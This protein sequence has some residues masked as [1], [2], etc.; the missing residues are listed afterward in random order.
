M[1]HWLVSMAVLSLA[2]GAGASD[3]PL[4]APAT[5]RALAAELS[6]ESARRTVDALARH[7]RMRGSRGF[8]AAATHVVEE[9][10]AAG[11]EDARLERFPSDG[12]ALYGSQ[13]S[14]RPW[15]ADFAELW[16]LD[17]QGGRRQRIASW[18][19]QPLCLAQDSES[20]EATAG[21][22]D[23][24]PG[25]SESDYAG[26]DVR[27]RLALV[28]AQPGAA[29]ALAVGAHGAA[30]IVSDAQNQR[31][32][33]W[34]EDQ[35]L[36]R[37]GHLDTF[38]AHP[39]F[40][41]MVSPAQARAWRDRLARGEAVRLHAKVVAGQHDG[42]LEL[43]MASLPGADPALRE[44]EIVF[45][46]HLD[47]PSPG[48]NDNASGCA[49]ILE[50][51][52]TLSRLVAQDRIARPAR[53]IRWVFPPEIE[54]THTLLHARPELAGRIKAVV[55][56]DM[57]GGG[58][59]TKAVFHVTRGPASLPSFVNDVAEALA[60]FVND[61]TDALASGRPTSYPLVAAGGDKRALQAEMA[62]FT[63]GSDH[64]V[65]TEASFAIPAVYLN[66]WPD[67]YIHTDRDVP[68]NIDA[69]K[70]E[71]AAFIGAAT[72]LVL[73]NA[74]AAEGPALWRVAR[75]RSLR[76]TAR[77]IERQASQPADE[78]AALARF[79]LWH[80]RT[81]AESL[82]RFFTPAPGLRTELLAHQD[83]TARLM[84]PLPEAP[85][86]TG[87]AARVYR[88]QP[89]PKGALGAFGYDFLT[90]KVGAEKA[91]ALR[92]L[93]YEGTRGGGDAYAY[94]ALNL[95]D[96]T[97]TLQE[98]RDM[99]SAIYGPVPLDLV[100]EYVETLEGIGVVSRVTGSR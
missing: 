97:R 35:S 88:R 43:A 56:M 66:D 27:G 74:T 3:P 34:G 94:E 46:C 75:A 98:V 48:A 87:G 69:S 13:R 58:E 31:T 72:A 77:A 49:A 61:E 59:A 6:G 91:R 22:V 65:Y 57:V 7:H 51:A 92:L 36:V 54:G 29:A 41:F 21:L 30:G 70:L 28:A 68:A 96:G 15:D 86:P 37:W 42:P 79:H 10:R 55:H 93:S 90:E 5:A 23:V 1:R 40:A 83:A 76:R 39:T 85:R 45:S 71:R 81:L 19:A 62:E 20:G 73:A 8:H 17:A 9:L 4:V 38:A 32:A 80:E 14:R 84:G 64:Q 2:Q 82:G 47:H 95:I 16:E 24:G 63:M 60:E 100:S 50:V 44:Q 89:R 52:R 26:K 53:T 67:R 33:W 12:R 11:L 78:A 99:L 25:T 18:E